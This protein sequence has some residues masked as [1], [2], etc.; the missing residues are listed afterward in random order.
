MAEGPHIEADSTVAV[1]DVA[2]VRSTAVAGAENT[3][4]LFTAVRFVTMLDRIVVLETVVGSV[5]VK[6]LSNVVVAFV[7]GG[8]L[9][10]LLNDTFV[11]FPIGGGGPADS[12]SAVVAEA[13]WDNS[14]VK[15][16]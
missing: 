5:I 14:T 13:F 3:K 8:R 15:G 12:P 1:E 10:E 7:V 2:L 9:V 16:S 6:L 11:A 4:L